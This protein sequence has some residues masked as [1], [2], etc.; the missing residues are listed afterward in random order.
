MGTMGFQTGAVTGLDYFGARYFSAAQGRFTSPDAPFADQHPEDPQSWNM[1]AYVRSNPL[2]NTDPDGRDCQNGFAA[3][4]NYVWGGV[5]AVVNAF[6][7]GIINAPNRILDAA[8]S[9]VAPSSTFR[10]GD[11][12]PDAFTP[13]NSEQR[14][15]LDSA[16][17]VMLAAPL[18]EAGAT[19]LVNAVG[20][21]A[22]VEAGAAAAVQ[23][24]GTVYKL[25]A[26][27]GSGKPYIGRTTKSAEERMATRAD[28][29]TGPAERV[30][31]FNAQDRAHGQYKEQKAI[32]ANGGVKNL[33]NKRNEVN[34]KRYEELTK[35][36]EGQQ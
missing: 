8:I 18:A 35:K 11:V 28:G 27:E 21:G 25:P 1:Y 23:E 20:T 22:R 14:Q 29:R 17:A 5:G 4:G 19:A 13:M 26:Q 36:Y 32:N 15:G 3:C 30:D 2:K 34:P 16:N 7:S 33:D 10:F 6:G 31:T 24:T 9:A 12:V